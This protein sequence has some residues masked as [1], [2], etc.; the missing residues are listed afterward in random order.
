MKKI[1]VIFLFLNI[2]LFAQSDNNNQSIELPAFVITGIQSIT[3]PTINKRKSD[4]IPIVG[5][6]FLTPQ[7]GSE[8]FAL[9]DNTNPIK[10][11][12][13]LYSSVESYSGLLYL[14]AGTE[15]LPIG[16]LDLSFNKNNFLFNTH[17]YGSDV[18]EFVPYAGY[19]TSGAEINLSYFLNHKSNAFP[20]L[21]INLGG[22]F[23]RDQYNFYGSDIPT[24]QRENEKYGGKIDFINQLNRD[25]LY[26]LSFSGNYLN[27]KTDEVKENLGRVNGFL[28]FSLGAFSFGADGF[29]STQQV[30]SSQIHDTNFNYFG[31]DG[32]LRFSSSNIFHFKIGAH[33]SQQDTNNVFSPIA[34]LSIFLEEGVALFF[35]YE[36]KS[37]FLTISDFLNEN[38]YYESVQQNIFQINNSKMNVSVKYDFSDVFEINAGFY[39]AKF[40][41]YHYYEDLT[42]NNRFSLVQ[43]NEIK[44]TGAFFNVIINTKSY[45]ELYADF[46][47][48]DVKDISGNKIPYKPVFKSSLSY[49]LFFNFG[50]YSKVRV[51]YASKYYSDL[52]N[53]NRLPNYINLDFLLKYNIFNTLA[54]TCDFQ[55]ILNRKN[56]IFKGYQEKSFDIIAG[57]EYRW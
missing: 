14:G 2:N 56:Y 24:Y 47:F 31:G 33:Y 30:K 25:F 23:V 37:D 35:S 15:T 50:L 38:R 27:M 34:V 20:G 48:Q 53:T 7:Y 12:M 55:N 10:K 46:D 42:N 49:G 51:R 54:L 8:D 4:F 28:E 40:D 5:T 18:G 21:K 9:M 17:I 6:N 1:L 57:I 26:G 41:N 19:N 32:Y 22:E 44:E 11:Q 52:L 39:S 29:Y 36:G 16:K 3:L 43:I 45:G 13:D